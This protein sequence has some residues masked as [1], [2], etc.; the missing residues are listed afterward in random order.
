[1]FVKKI[2]K[3]PVTWEM[4]GVIEVEAES[5][6]EAIEIVRTD[7]EDI[8]LP[9][10]SH[11]VDDSFRLSSDCEKE[12]L[13]MVEN[14]DFELEGDRE[15][16]KEVF[17]IKLFLLDRYGDE[18]TQEELPG[19]KESNKETKGSSDQTSTLAEITSKVLQI[20]GLLESKGFDVSDIEN[21]L[22]SVFSSYDKEGQNGLAK[23][24]EQVGLTR[25]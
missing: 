10:E 20:I 11:Y 9:G 24:C 21:D 17:H 8:S 22:N 12:M 7:K 25:K 5:P 1:M 4:Y 18:I 15:I 16:L 23:F 19:L 3:V 13:A 6:E 2:F 14:T